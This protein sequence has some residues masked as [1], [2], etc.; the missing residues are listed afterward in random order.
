[1]VCQSKISAVGKKSG[2]EP[3]IKLDFHADTCMVSMGL[4]ILDTLDMGF[5]VYPYSSK[6]ETKIVTLVN[7]ITSYNHPGG[8]TYLLRVNKY[9]GML[10]E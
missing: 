1:M 4:A 7:S 6:Y 3:K 8:N 2:V 5:K 9:L 10:E